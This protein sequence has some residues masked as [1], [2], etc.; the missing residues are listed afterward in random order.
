MEIDKI[1]N[2]NKIIIYFKNQGYEDEWIKLY[3]LKKYKN[4]DLVN[5]TIQR[6][7][8]S[9][10]RRRIIERDNVCLISGL[11][12]I[13]C[14]AAH[15]IPYSICKNYDLSNGLLLN[16]CLHKLFDEY[17]FSINPKTSKIIIKNGITNLSI[18]KYKNK[19]INIPNDCRSNLKNH[20]KLFKNKNN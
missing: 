12:S 10:F 9:E 11:N 15:I 1:D 16:M 14:E 4:D 19:I 13:E 8:Q 18:N 6:I 20:Y 7:Y 2:I 5:E 17:I 3:L